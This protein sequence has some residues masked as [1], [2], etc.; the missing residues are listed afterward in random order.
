MK[1]LSLFVF[2]FLV[3][4]SEGIVEQ[5]RDCCATYQEP[6]FDTNLARLVP[7]GASESGF[8]ELLD[9]ADKKRK[10]QSSTVYVFNNATGAFFEQGLVVWITV[11]QATRKITAIQSAIASN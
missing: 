10:D 1:Y 3:G 6:G 9:V 11:N 7:V 2:L 4:C 8:Q 5:F